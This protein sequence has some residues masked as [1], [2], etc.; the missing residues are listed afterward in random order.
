M[1]AASMVVLCVTSIVAG[2][3]DMPVRVSP[4]VSSTVCTMAL[5]PSFATVRV[6]D[7]LRFAAVSA[8]QLTSPSEWVWSS[9]DTT[10]VRTDDTGLSRALSATTGVA[11]C[12]AFRA[13]GRL[14][15]CASVAVTSP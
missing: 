3:G 10:K 14:K 1:R 13:D 7:T 12:A 15:S 9:S 2:C 5:V 6:A 4:C 8:P 11:V